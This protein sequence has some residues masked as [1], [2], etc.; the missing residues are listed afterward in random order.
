LAPRIG[1]DS[2]AEYLNRV[3]LEGNCKLL[4]YDCYAQMQSEFDGLDVYF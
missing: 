1:A 2:L 4:S 3:V